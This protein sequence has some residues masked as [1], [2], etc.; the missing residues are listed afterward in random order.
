MYN[1]VVSTLVHTS[2]SLPYSLV[3]AQ[4]FYIIGIT[5]GLDGLNT[6]TSAQG[7]ASDGAVPYN[8]TTLFGVTAIM[9]PGMLMLTDSWVTHV[10]KYS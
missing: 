6:V 7:F 5:N 3:G 10:G 8:A 4:V 9:L 2:G 1:V